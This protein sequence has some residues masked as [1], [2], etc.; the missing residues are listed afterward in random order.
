MDQTAHIDNAAGW[1]CLSLMFGIDEF[2]FWFYG[3]GQI[4]QIVVPKETRTLLSFV[5]AL[6]LVDPECNNFV[7]LTQVLQ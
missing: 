1:Y 7:N 6:Y 3:A 4:E 2:K 5:Y